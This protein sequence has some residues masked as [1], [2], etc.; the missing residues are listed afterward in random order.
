MREWNAEMFSRRAPIKMLRMKLPDI[1]RTKHAKA[2]KCNIC[3]AHIETKNAHKNRI[4]NAGVKACHA[5]DT[6][7]QAMQSIAASKQR[8][9][10]KK[11]SKFQ[12]NF[13]DNEEI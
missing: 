7:F 13:G 3:L 4:K 12:N 10:W 9:K 11:V 5:I 6:I 2:W 1:M 8:A